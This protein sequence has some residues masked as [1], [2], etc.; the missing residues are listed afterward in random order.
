MTVRC[1]SSSAEV[2]HYSKPTLHDIVTVGNEPKTDGKG[3]NGNLPSRNGLQIEVSSSL[4][5][6]V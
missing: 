2:Q 3:H 4:Y 5:Q 6:I 1:V